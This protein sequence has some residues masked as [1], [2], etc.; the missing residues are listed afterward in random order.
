MSN[1]CVIRRIKHSGT[2]YTTK[3]LFTVWFLFYYFLQKL[4]SAFIFISHYYFHVQHHL[5]HP[6]A[7]HAT[8]L[9][10]K[11]LNRDE[12]SIRRWAKG[13]TSKLFL[14]FF[15][16]PLH[17]LRAW[18]Q[19]FCSSALPHVSAFNFRIPT[20]KKLSVVI[21]LYTSTVWMSKLL[22]VFIYQT[23]CINYGFLFLC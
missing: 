3:T 5:D 15:F 8:Q 21:M 17:V 1:C 6:E 23:K 4:L 20:L 22:R 9:K 18:I 11:P 12:I 7:S 16:S 10:A 13:S 14:S 2:C 19:W